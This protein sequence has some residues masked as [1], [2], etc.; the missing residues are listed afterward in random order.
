MIAPRATNASVGQRGAQSS[1]ATTTSGAPWTQQGSDG[2]NAAPF[3]VDDN[4]TRSSEDDHGSRSTKD[5]CFPNGNRSRSLRCSRIYSPHLAPEI[6]YQMV[7]MTCVAFALAAPPPFAAPPPPF[8]VPLPLRR[9]CCYYAPINDD[10]I[11]A[12]SSCSSH[13]Q[14][15]RSNRSDHLIRRDRRNRHD[16]RHNHDG[17]R[18]PTSRARKSNSSC[19][20]SL[21]Q[22]FNKDTD[23]YGTATIVLCS[24]V[25]SYR[26]KNAISSEMYW[27]I[28]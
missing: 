21:C 26:V 27:P 9:R 18:T 23:I 20:C 14:R 15:G 16:L 28:V 17:N 6:I 4:D 10:K 13:C 11:P 22:S 1:R 8:V 24:L 19:Y 3:C 5:D 25:A 7:T 12:R 2:I